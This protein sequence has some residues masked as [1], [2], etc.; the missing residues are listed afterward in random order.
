MKAITL[1]NGER[2]TFPNE[3]PDAEIINSYVNTLLGVDVG[4]EEEE[5]KEQAG[6]FGALREG[7]TSLGDVPEAV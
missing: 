2:L 4:V 3:T 6:F 1:P 5:E 7:I